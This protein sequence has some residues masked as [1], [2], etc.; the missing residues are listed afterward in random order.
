MLMLCVIGALI[1]RACEPAHPGATST[2][3]AAPADAQAAST[4]GAAPATAALSALAPDSNIAQVIGALNLVTI[5]FGATSSTL[6]EAAE[7]VLTKVAVVL[8]ARP[9][10]ERL[11]V[12]AHADDAGSPLANLE[13]SRRRAQAVVDF[14]I[15]QGVPTQFLRARGIGDPEPVQNEPGQALSLRNPRIQFTLLP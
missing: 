7:P 13:L 14:L 10:L 2:A 1:I 8:S 5:D 3:S 9:S 4:S 6:P 11:E 15:N 12:S